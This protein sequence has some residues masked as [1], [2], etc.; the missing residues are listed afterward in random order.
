MSSPSDPSSATPP[1]PAHLSTEGRGAEQEHHGGSEDGRPGDSDG[2][3][4]HGGGEGG[5]GH[6]QARLRAL[7]G[8]GVLALDRRGSQGVPNISQCVIQT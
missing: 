5:G 1:T 4:L 8:Q 2:D 3:C 7:T 6:L